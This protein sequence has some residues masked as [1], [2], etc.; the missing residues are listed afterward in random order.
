MYDQPIMNCKYIVRPYL[1]D[2]VNIIVST[3]RAFTTFSSVSSTSLA[4]VVPGGIATGRS[5]PIVYNAGSI[6]PGGIV[7]SSRI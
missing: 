3:V 4:S 2:V 1:Y 5:L 6:S 7:L